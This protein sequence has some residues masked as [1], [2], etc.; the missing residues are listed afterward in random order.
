MGEGESVVDSLRLW[1]SQIVHSSCCF[2][3]AVAAGEATTV[4]QHL[5]HM[6]ESVLGWLMSLEDVIVFIML[7]LVSRLSS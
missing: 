6:D 2:A 5:H 1:S 7:S 4:A 3:C